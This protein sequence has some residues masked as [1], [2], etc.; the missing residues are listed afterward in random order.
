MSIPLQGGGNER[1][2]V[3]E[4]QSGKILIGPAA[5]TELTLKK[6]L[7]KHPTYEVLQPGQKP[8]PN[9]AA[10]LSKLWRCQYLFT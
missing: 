6:W 2:V 9:P 7:E 8:G 3:L 5:P 4:R 10:L 1:I